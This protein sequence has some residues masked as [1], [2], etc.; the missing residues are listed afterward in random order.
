MFFWPK[1][2]IPDPAPFQYKSE[3]VLSHQSSHSSNAP[4]LQ[5]LTFANCGRQ[6]HDQD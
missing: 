1:Y 3:F 2:G 4:I 6:N 5:A